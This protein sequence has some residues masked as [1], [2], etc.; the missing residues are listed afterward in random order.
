MGNVVIC[1]KCGRENSLSQ[2]QNYCA[3]CGNSLRPSEHASREPSGDASFQE[4]APGSSYNTSDRSEGFHS[5][6]WEKLDETG[7]LQGFFLTLKQSLFEPTRFFSRLP[8]SGG[9]I[10]PIFY[11]VLIGTIG[12]L[13]GYL[14]GTLLDIPWVSQGKWSPGFTLF[15]GLIMPLLVLLGIVL[16]S[17][18]LHASLLLFGAKKEPF[19]GTLRIIS[20]SSSPEVFNALPGIGWL[21]AVI[22]KLVLTVIGVREVQ[23]VSTGRALLAVL[24][25]V[26]AVWA[27]FFTGIL[28]L[29]ALGVFLVGSI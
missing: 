8:R 22:W 23:G 3:F 20:Y 25:A 18:L 11:G 15:L 27:I 14:L 12:N 2:G 9:W 29:I 28:V 17:I 5:C 7:F 16:W 13:G 6:P 21:V 26:F 4:D 1:T 19:E 10:N 24:F